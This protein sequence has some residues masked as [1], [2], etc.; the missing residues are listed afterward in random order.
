MIRTLSL[1]IGYYGNKHGEWIDRK[2]LIVETIIETRADIVALQA[3]CADPDI[4]NGT[5][6]VAQ[7]SKGL[8][9]YPYYIF[10][11][12]SRKP[13][14]RQEGNAI[15][16]KLPIL[17]TDTSLLQL[18]SGDEDPVQRLLVRC[19]FEVNNKKFQVIN[20]HFSWVKEQTA[21]NVSNAL[22]IL[23]S[24]TEDAI[25][26]GDLNTDPKDQLLA[27]LV[28]IGW[29]DMW[30]KLNSGEQGYTFE[31]DKPFT[32]VDYA[33]ANE[34]MKEKIKSIAVVKKA[35]NDMVRLSDHFGLLIHLQV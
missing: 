27:P 17:N 18:N 2:K 10:S 28:Q 25:L 22:P 30:E 32:R 14:G 6:Q 31:S 34:S 13:N 11:P 3:V 21:Q 35:N 9:N 1:N 5:N 24:I 16:S 15:L 12:V 20:G 26:I 19:L 29:T 8:Q 7:L 4:E 23:S 33:W